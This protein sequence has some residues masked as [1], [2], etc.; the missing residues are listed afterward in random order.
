MSGLTQAQKSM[1]TFVDISICLEKGFV[2]S[3]T[4]RTMYCC[5]QNPATGCL[6]LHEIIAQFTFLL[7]SQLFI[8]MYI[9]KM[10]WSLSSIRVPPLYFV[11]QET[12]PKS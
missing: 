2:A 5:T 11:G 10:K 3:V 1:Q 6:Q 12:D 7:L 9:F 8:P 4:F